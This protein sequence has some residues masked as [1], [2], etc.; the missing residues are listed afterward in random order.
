MSVRVSGW[1]LRRKCKTVSVYP[2]GVSHT[3][4]SRHIDEKSAD[5]SKPCLK[6]QVNG[7]QT[8]LSEEEETTVGWEDGRFHKGGRSC[9]DL[10]EW[11]EGWFLFF[12]LRLLF[13]RSLRSF[14]IHA[15]IVHKICT[16]KENGALS[17]QFLEARITM[18]IIWIRAM[19]K[20]FLSHFT[21]KSRCNHSL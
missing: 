1:D 20:W 16:R 9:F 11:G 12:F 3:V 19:R 14:R 18:T 5:D 4:E 15:K 21:Y 2:L 7:F 13:K 8:K 10:E 6:W 17:I